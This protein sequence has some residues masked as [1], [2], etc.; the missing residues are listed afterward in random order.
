M[1]RAF[2]IL[3]IFLVSLMAEARSGREPVINSCT[4]KAGWSRV[5]ITPDESVWM[6]GYALRDHPSEGV[7]EDLWAKSLY[8]EDSLGNKGVLV[9]MDLLSIPMDFSD[10]IRNELSDKFGLDRSQ[11]ILN[12][13]HTHSGPVIGRALR[14]IYPMKE[15]DW[16]KVDLYT[17]WL[18][19]Q[20]IDLVDVSMRTSTPVRLSSG[21]GVARFAINR[22]NNVESHLSPMCEY[23]GPHDHSVPVLSIA[24]LDGTLRVILFGYACHNTVISDYMFSGDYAGYAQKELECRHPGIQAMFFQGAGGDQN[25]IPRRKVSYAIQYGNE[26]AAAVEQA[27]ADEMLL[28][29]NSY[30]IMRYTEISLPMENILPLQELEKIGQRNDYQARWARGMI[31]ELQSGKSLPNKYPY[32]IQYWQIGSQ[33][34]FILGGEVVSEYAVNLK[35]I[36]GS[37]IFVLGYSNDVMSYIPST[38]IWDEGRYEGAV[39]HMVYA[40]PARWTRDVED[41][42]LDAIQ[43]LVPPK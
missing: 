32:P 34:M 19:K 6:A 23:K 29:T 25:P 7:R 31:H 39:A 37:D 42:I 28:I 1:K 36:Y 17:E 30:L 21:Q 43:S 35:K 12:V 10:A 8:L 33:K 41:R 16:E 9:T 18:H 14:Y 26:L 11:V 40:L 20:I 27:I 22:R 13:S 4:W 15:S 2:A 5:K 3:S 24:T 38:I